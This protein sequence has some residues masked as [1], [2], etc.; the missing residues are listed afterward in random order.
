M[1]PADIERVVEPVW[2]RR[3]PDTPLTKEGKH[4]SRRELKRGLKEYYDPK[5]AK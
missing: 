2:A 1:E 5:S 3:W 4:V